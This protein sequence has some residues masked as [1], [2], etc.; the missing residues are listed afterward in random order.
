MFLP[1]T[2]LMSLL[3]SVPATTLYNNVVADV[4]C[5]L[6][7]KYNSYHY[8]LS[9]VTVFLQLKNYPEGCESKPIATEVRIL[10]CET[11]V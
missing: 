9:S 3:M 4:K 2:T 10:L 1:A 8:C 5:E 11:S 6:Y 7:V